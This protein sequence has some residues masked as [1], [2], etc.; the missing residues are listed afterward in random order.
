[1]KHNTL[2]NNLTARIKHKLE[3]FYT[4][5]KKAKLILEDYFRKNE[6][7]KIHNVNS[8]FSDKSEMKF[9]PHPSLDP[10]TDSQFAEYH[11]CP[12]NF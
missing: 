1:M 6:F 12:V 4:H 5:E 7:L 11:C 8:K 3:I 9:I 2:N 10:L